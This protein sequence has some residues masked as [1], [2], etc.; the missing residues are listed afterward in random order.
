MDCRTTAVKEKKIGVLLGGLSAEREVSLKT[1]A[2]ILEALLSRGYRAV[3]IDVD[4]QVCRRLQEEGIEVAFLAL[5]GR[6][7]EDGAIQGVLEY[8]QIPYTGPGILASGL[9]MNKLA[10]KRMVR[11]AGLPT[12]DYQVCRAAGDVDL[13][14]PCPVVVKPVNEGSSLGISVVREPGSLPAA[15][16]QAFAY[17]GEVLIEK[18]VAGKEVTAAV[19]DDQPLPLIEIRPASGFYDYRAKYTP[20]QTE[21]LVPAPLAVKTAARLQKLAVAACRVTG[22]DCGAVRVDFRLDSEDNPYIIEINTI[23]GM[24]ATSLL[25]K[26]ALAAG[27]DF[28]SLI[29]KI[30]CGASLKFNL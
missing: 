19:L 18:Y 8:L 9:A 11:S 29:E 5:H 15:L 12:P 13:Q 24:T 22:C 7:G 16:E 25:P 27:L 17:D 23:P 30:V 20:G 28:P 2:A 21:Y 1:G 6:Y 3:A 26:A 10:T 4:R 14:L